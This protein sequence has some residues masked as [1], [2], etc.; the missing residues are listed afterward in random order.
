[1]FERLLGPRASLLR[2]LILKVSLTLF[3]VPVAAWEASDREIGKRMHPRLLSG[4]GGAY[5]DAKLA[6]YVDKV[7]RRLTR[8]TKHG[9][10]HWR[11]TVI[12]TPVVNAFALPGGYVYVTRGLLAL[13]NDEA[14]LAGVLGHE[15][16]HV[17]ARHG[18]KRQRE[19]AKAGIGLVLGTVLGGALGGK[20]GAEDVLRLGSK[21]AQGYLAGHSRQQE[22]EADNIG[23][24]ILARAGYDPMAQ[25]DFL[26]NLSRK[27]ALLAQISGKDYDPHRVDF[28]ASH[29][30]TGQRVREAVRAARKNGHISGASKTRKSEA[31]LR[32]IDGMV[33][34]DSR[35]QGFVRGQSFLHP[36]MRFA[37][38]VPKPFR[39]V[40]ASRSVTAVGPNSS[41]LVM[42]ATKDPG[43]SLTAYIRSTWVPALQK[44]NRLGSINRLR[45]TKINGLP[46]A[47]AFVSVTGRRGVEQVQL[48]AVR[49]GQRVFRLMAITGSADTKLRYALDGAVRSF[50]SLSKSEAAALQP[51][52]IRAYKAKRGDR[53]G[54]LAA[55]MPMDQ[56]RVERFRT[57]N[58]MDASDRVKSGQSL[59][60]VRD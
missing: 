10:D 49:Y 21:L 2:S 31:Y 16:G 41:R 35:R 17:I 28:F 50:R 33:Y 34:G 29:P 13:A 42:D 54:P 20:E 27:H 3:A 26:E 11:F 37:F 59:K 57:L 60:L 38:K 24:R 32:Q 47:T 19:G 12:D 51:Y 36:E 55:T 48:T 22:F 15:I 52:R 8:Y 23:V 46:A 44:K 18:V 5:E 6:G 39:I 1:M 53:L 40:N 30:A 56:F 14:E 58:G 7:G 9:K 43:G 25:A 45:A 4:M